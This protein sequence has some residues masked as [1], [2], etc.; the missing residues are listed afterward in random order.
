MRS[1]RLG[2]FAAALFAALPARLVAQTGS[3]AGL[4]TGRTGGQPLEGVDVAV[5][6][7]GQANT[8]A[9]TGADGRF[10][11]T[12]LSAGTYI[13]E[14]RRVG[15]QFGR[16]GNVVV[17]SGGT[18]TVDLQLGE[19]VIQLDAIV[20]TV[21]RQPEK[22][23][24]APASVHVIQEM[25]IRERPALTVTDQIKNLPGV[26]VSQGGL[27]QSNIVSRGFNNIFSGAT[28]VLVDNRFAHVPSLRVNVPAFVST[29]NDD[30]EQMEFVLGPGAALYGPNS[31]KGVLAITT[32]SPLTSVGNTIWVE[33]G[34]RAGSRDS[35]GNKLDDHQPLGRLG[36]RFAVADERVGFK[37]SGEYLRGTDWRYRDPAEP[38]TIPN[39]SPGL[40]STA[41]GCRGDFNLEKW[42]VDTRLDIKTGD[43]SEVI[44]AAGRNMAVN[45]IEP[46][47]S[48]AAQT[49]DWGFSYVQTRFRQGRVFLQG[50]GNFS[51]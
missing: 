32:R 51:S 6:V 15:Y 41:F 50:V 40:C 34:F 9:T 44:M 14:V 17:Q 23:L 20:V 12:G 24:D 28:L 38:A 35:A 37:I 26:D 21:G 8:R 4:I 39:V 1:T 36:G 7:G 25:E 5:L 19:S 42:N 49:R 13:V 33:S 11:I 43:D 31:A 3:I 16:V 30:I 47:G 18:A 29:T 2:L 46:T 48:G 10:R 27:V 22:Q 45:L